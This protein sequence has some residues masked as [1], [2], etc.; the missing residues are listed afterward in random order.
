MTL[1]WWLSI[2]WWLIELW[3]FAL[4]FY[5]LTHSSNVANL[6]R[7]DFKETCV[8][9]FPVFIKNRYLKKF[10]LTLL[11]GQFWIFEKLQKKLQKIHRWKC[12]RSFFCVQ[13][14]ETFGCFDFLA[15]YNSS[16]IKLSDLFKTF[17]EV[18]L[19][20][21]TS[22]KYIKQASLLKGLFCS[23]TFFVFWNNK[24][25]FFFWMFKVNK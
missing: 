25:K 19:K 9:V 7:L 5:K 24:V 11:S 3:K 18:N 20:L 10:N 22:K 16:N 12:I 14:V 2:P 1:V 4:I 23:T 21:A 15:P 13:S 6:I 8:T 17:W